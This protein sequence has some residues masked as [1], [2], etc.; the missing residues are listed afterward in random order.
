MRRLCGLKLMG[1]AGVSAFALLAAGAASAQEATPLT[2]GQQAEGTLEDGDTLNDSGILY[3]SYALTLLAGQRI[4]IEMRSD[5]LDAYLELYEPGDTS[6][7]LVAVDDD[8]DTVGGDGTDARLRYTAEVDGLYTLR[9]RA[10]SEG[11]SGAYTLTTRERPP[12]PPAPEPGIIT[13]GQS[14]DGVIDDGDPVDSD[15]V[16]YDAWRFSAAAGERLI[17]TL[18]SDDFD[19]YLQVGRQGADGGFEEL[20]FND[21]DGETLNSRLVFTAPDLADYLIRARPL[22]PGEFG[23]Y[24]LSLEVAPPPPEA[25]RLSIGESQNGTLGADSALND[26]GY[27]ARHYRF[28]GREGQRIEI[29]LEADDFDTYVVLYREEG[30]APVRLDE[31]DD[32]SGTNSRLLHT[33]DS[34][35]P[36]LIEVRGF[37]QMAEGAYTLRLTEVPPERP[38]VPLAYGAVVE[39]GIDD[40]D[41]TDDQQRGFDSYVFSGVEGNRVQII[42]RSGDFDTFL[43]IGAA[44]GEFD[45]LASDD[46]GLGEGTDSRLN[47]TLPE[48]GD[49][50]VRVSPL[51]SDNEGLYSVQLTDRGPAPGPGSILPGATARG[52]LSEADATSGD[53]SYFDAYRINAKGGGTL[54][55]TMVSNSF[56]A[57]VIV[58]REKVDDE[59]EVLA[60]DDDG[61]SD[62]HSRLEWE[63]PEDGVYIIRAGSFG[64]AETGAYA[65]TV[66]RKP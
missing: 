22:S 11:E 49:Y 43:R 6:A 3:D 40:R 38:P 24:K 23:A 28:T 63:V 19:A 53:G 1:L 8:D 54:V 62:T 18:T 59:I 32:A 25:L 20:A 5:A 57:F 34:P 35:G 45:P 29:L 33:L 2:L 9:A 58:G 27:R 42:A 17:V 55:I 46:D 48:T 44:G 21:D 37:S 61:L 15:D 36:Y 12:A 64:Q 16:A 50:V 10:F 60:S 26:E 39:G 14:V 51:S 52:T 56:D 4:E 31:N 30:G 41:P 66:E 65:L 13:R 47:F 7:E